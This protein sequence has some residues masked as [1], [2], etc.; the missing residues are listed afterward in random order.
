[1]IW[2]VLSIEQFLAKIL[3]KGK[4]PPFSGFSAPYGDAL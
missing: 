1:M 2:I 3:K 4:N